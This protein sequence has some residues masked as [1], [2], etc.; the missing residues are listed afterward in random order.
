MAK[1]PEPI[2]KLEENGTASVISYNVPEPTSYTGRNFIELDV[3]RGDFLPA[4]FEKPEEEEE[5][6]SLGVRLGN[7]NLDPVIVRNAGGITKAPVGTVVKTGAKVKAPAATAAKAA[8]GP[9][10]PAAPTPAPQPAPDAAMSALRG[11]TR[12]KWH[13][14]AAG[15]YRVEANVPVSKALQQ[16]TP[17]EAVTA[18]HQ[19]LQP[20]IYRN[21][22]GTYTV[23]Y[24]PQPEES[25]PRLLLVESYRLSSYLGSYGAGRTMKTYS[26]FPGE[27]STISVKTYKQTETEAKSASSILDSFTET[28]ADE[29]ETS[30]ATEQ[31]DTETYEKSK[32]YGVEADA[33]AAWGW[34]SVN[35][36]GSYSGSTQSSREEFAKNISNATEKHAATASAK[37]EVQIETSYQV[38]ETE[39]EETSIVREFQN[40]NVS[41]TLNF[42]FRQ[43]NQ[44]FIT[45]LHLVDVRVAFF[46]GFPE[47]T[48]EVSLPDLDSLLAEYV[49]EG[50][51]EAVKQQ[52]VR[53]L[54]AILD[55][56]D[57]PHQFV[58]KRRLTA[59]DG[60]AFEYYRA[61]KDYTSEYKDEATG[62][63]ITVPGII[64][65]ANKHVL[66]TD[67]V[68]VEALLGQA[69]SLDAYSQSLQDQTVR[70]RELENEALAAELEKTRAALQ[71][72]RSRDKGAAEIFQ[73]VFPGPAADADE[74]GAE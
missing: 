70:A 29:F 41:R 62:T 31:S 45:I 44:E 47:M 24:V 48:R 71:I 49:V 32:N 27:K 54:S 68:I 37:R 6:A 5:G 28:S 7:L 15:G 34:G 39:G 64:L 21:L 52:I 11:R 26:L 3:S 74:A 50:K 63:S 38:K 17:Q 65:S 60:S 30:V 33:H 69:P 36:S 72:V 59:T 16:T 22:Y 23:A 46:N 19:G 13:A 8:P 57:K 14:N 66:R 25:A 2:I 18:Q 67:G 12:I 43:M 1:N 9:A 58:E 35:V 73:M 4:A 56:R 61:K 53:E 55:Y 20:V 40:I 42:V 10:G 51:R